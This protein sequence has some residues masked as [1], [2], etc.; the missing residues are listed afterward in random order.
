VLG[1]KKHNFG[2]LLFFYFLLFIY[3]K[4]KQ[5]KKEKQAMKIKRFEGKLFLK[6]STICD[7]NMLEK[8]EVKGGAIPIDA[9]ESLILQQCPTYL[10]SCLGTICALSNWYCC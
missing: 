2:D 6:K 10:K 5:Q 8:G 1:N 7:L 9:P 3:V 4:N